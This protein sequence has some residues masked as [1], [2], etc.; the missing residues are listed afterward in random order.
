[1]FWGCFWSNIKGPVVFWE[2]EWGSITEESYRA[3][4][5]PLIH[6]WLR[7]NKEEG[8]TLTF[9]QDSTPAYAARGT[10]EDLRERGVVCIQWPSFSPDLNPIEMVWN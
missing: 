10:I 2:K 9:M 7:I 6:G 8:N 3:R 1:M 4:I 5:I